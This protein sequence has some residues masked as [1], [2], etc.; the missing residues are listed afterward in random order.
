MSENT[1]NRIFVALSFFAGFCYGLTLNFN[2]AEYIVDGLIIIYLVVS[3]VKLRSKLRDPVWVK[4][5]RSDLHSLSAKFLM[6][7]PALMGMHILQIFH[8]YGLS[9]LYILVCA[10]LLEEGRRLRNGWKPF[11]PIYRKK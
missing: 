1:I 2:M 7:A 8:M 5:N 10:L 11:I 6:V 9:L 4:E 3:Y